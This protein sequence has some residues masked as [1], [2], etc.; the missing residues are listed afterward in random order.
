MQPVTP[1]SSGVVA[2]SLTKHV[3]TRT[4]WQ[5]LSFSIHPGECVAITGASG[6]GKSTLLHC[7]A[8]LDYPNQGTLTFN[9]QPVPIKEGRAMQT[10][11]RQC[12]GYLFQDFAMVTEK[13]A[14]DNVVAALPGSP[15]RAQATQDLAARALDAVGLTYIDREAPVAQLSGGEQ[16]RVALARIIAKAPPLVVADEPTGSLDSANGD[17]VTRSLRDMANAGAVVIVATHDDAVA[18]MCDKRLHL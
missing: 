13:S 14:I 5:G 8:G 6:S 12:L 9:G 17:V 11:R 15:R 3:G 2:E 16:Q 4:L 1:L 18:A 7:I 10:Y